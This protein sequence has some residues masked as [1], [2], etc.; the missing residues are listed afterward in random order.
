MTPAAGA[1][2]PVRAQ[3]NASFS[4]YAGAAANATFALVTPEGERRWDPDFHPRYFTKTTAEAGTVFDTTEAGKYHVW[5]LDSI[6]AR[7]HRVRYIAILPGHVL[8][9][10]DVA[11]TPV[12]A[13]RSS[14]TVTYHRVSLSARDDEDVRHFPIH[15]QHLRQQWEQAFAKALA[16]A[17]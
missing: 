15:V 5:L 2:S 10:I 11:V 9:T 14:V 6:D 1:T 12:A 13:G 4:F 8:T 16:G 3:S 7:H 17:S